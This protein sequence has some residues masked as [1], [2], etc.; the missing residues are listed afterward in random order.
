MAQKSKWTDRIHHPISVL[1]HAD[2]LHLEKF[3][4]EDLDQIAGCDDVYDIHLCSNRTAQPVDLSRLAHITGLR[5]L[6]LERM[7]FTNLQA[8]KALP[9]LRFLIIENCDF[10]DLDALNGW[11]A[12][13][14]LFLR[15]NK[16]GRF[17]VGLDLPR[18][19]C[20]LLGDELI[21]DLGFAASYPQL[22]ELDVGHNKVTDLSP[23]AACTWLEKLN[24]GNNPITT[25]APL[26]GRRFKRLHV[27]N[28][29]CGERAA[30]QL[31]LPQE[32]YERDADSIEASR[33]ARLMEARDWPQVYAIADNA[34][35]GKAFSYLVHGHAEAEMIRG[36]L[37]HPA[38]GAFESMVENGLRPHYSSV[39]ELVVGIFSEFGERLIPPMA[40]ALHT[41]LNRA[42]Y[43]EAF[44]VGKLD[45]EH[46]TIAQ[47]LQ[48]VA[49][50]AYTDLFLAF[51]NLRE[52]FSQLHLRLYKRLLD[53][54]GKTQSPLL[55]EPLI[56]LLRF[57]KQV[58]GG[59]AAFM[60][61][62]F[63]AIGQLGGRGD[64]AVLAR[65]FDV[66][67]ETRPDVASVYQATMARLG[68]KKD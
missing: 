43:L 44:Y 27:D 45:R 8:L 17:P 10:K 5:T 68:K 66:A 57:E 16:L 30:L 60:K 12:L 23:L 46:F 36:A 3:T 21:A 35:L 50:P 18:L 59:D 20:L 47:V 24:V 61:K 14:T 64:A 63:K 58:I 37:A 32:P 56:D 26:A 48:S 53:G 7:K 11:P 4:D 28:A 54:V 49:G 19:D 2:G 62:I 67:A 6:N 65:R 31:E 34:M 15:R 9:H 51:F 40:R 25:L 29:L 42:T 55:V 1:N 38:P 39:S 41:A 22:K 13:A 33:I 52:D